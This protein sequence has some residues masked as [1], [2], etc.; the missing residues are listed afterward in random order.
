MRYV[1]WILL[2]ILH[3]SPAFARDDYFP[4]A[5]GDEWTMSVT[6]T[7]NQEPPQYGVYRRII[8]AA[9]D[10]NGK[11]YLHSKISFEGMPFKAEGMKL[12]RKDDHAVWSIDQRMENATERLETVLP[13]KTGSHWERNV[14]GMPMT[15]TVLGK[16]TIVIDGKTYKNCFHIQSTWSNGTFISDSWQAPNIGTVKKQLTYS[17]GLTFTYLLKE[18]KMPKLAAR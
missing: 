13:L 8:D 10:K 14:R 7:G 5:V 3:G 12:M 15:N 9:M 6:M 16:E 4:M 11:T 18:Y 1:L 17:D 2:L